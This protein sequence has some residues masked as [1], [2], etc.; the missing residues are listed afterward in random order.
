MFLRT[1]C[2]CGKCRGDSAHF[3]QGS[4]LQVLG[5][6]LLSVSKPLPCNSVSLLHHFFLPPSLP[7]LCRERI[8][9]NLRSS[10]FLLIYIVF[11][12]V[13][14]HLSLIRPA[15]SSSLG[16]GTVLPPLGVALGTVPPN[17]SPAGAFTASKRKLVPRFPPDDI[18]KV[19]RRRRP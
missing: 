1:Y 7:A 5:F 4:I 3:R 19:P 11:V 10:L 15:A 6:G 12:C 2:S 17:A 16:M 18:L 13:F 14:I 9:T 8:R